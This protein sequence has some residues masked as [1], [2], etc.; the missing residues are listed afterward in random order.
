MLL[1]AGA[2]VGPLE[3]YTAQITVTFNCL[4]TDRRRRSSP[5]LAFSFYPSPPLIPRRAT[6]TQN[7]NLLPPDTNLSLQEKWRA[8]VAVGRVYS[9]RWYMA[10]YLGLCIWA[11]TGG[12]QWAIRQYSNQSLDQ[13]QL[14]PVA[15]NR[16]ALSIK[17]STHETVIWIQL[18]KRM[19][20]D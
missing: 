11:I 3:C 7:R 9:L 20:F 8:S 4:L 6:S 14:I 2:F 18:I 17:T 13:Y 16:R 1:T 19:V 12:S 15:S 10:L 5:S